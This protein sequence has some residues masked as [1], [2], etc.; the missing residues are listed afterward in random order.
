MSNI[1]Y[2][3]PMTEESKKHIPKMLFDGDRFLYGN[4]WLGTAAYYKAMYPGFTDEQTQVFE[5]YSN[6][7][8][9]KQY[10]NILKKTK[11]KNQDVSNRKVK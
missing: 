3:T 10:R 7:V 9:A 5:M 4:N 6:G 8:T 1:N 2:P 11:R